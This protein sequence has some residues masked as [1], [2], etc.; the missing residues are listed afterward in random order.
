MSTRSPN[1]ASP[2]RRRS[3][4]MAFLAVAQLII[5]LVQIGWQLIASTPNYGVVLLACCGCVVALMQ[6]ASAVWQLRCLVD[7]RRRCAAG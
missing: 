1:G 5:W 3:I 7:T 2:T 4:I 6:L